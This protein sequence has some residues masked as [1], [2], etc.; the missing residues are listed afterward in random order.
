MNDCIFKYL[1]PRE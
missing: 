1:K